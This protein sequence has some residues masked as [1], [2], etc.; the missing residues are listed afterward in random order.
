[1][2]VFAYRLAYQN[3]LQDYYQDVREKEPDNDLMEFIGLAEMLGS[4]RG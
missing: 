1:M 3:N 4:R 2:D